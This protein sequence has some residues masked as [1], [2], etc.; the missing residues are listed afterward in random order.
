MQWK[1]LF[2]FTKDGKVKSADLL[3][4]FFLAVVTIFT[5]FVIANRLTFLFEEIL[6]GQTRAV[7]NMIDTMVPTI[8]CMLLA[9]ILFRIIKKKRIVLMSHWIAWITATAVLVIVLIM[10]D[11]ETLETLFFPLA[12]IFEVPA[13]ANTVLVTILFCRWRNRQK[14]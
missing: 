10:F 12:C 5:D 8:L 13:L 11:R 4:A 2:L 7:K 14:D 3:Y 9:A 6:D 1:D